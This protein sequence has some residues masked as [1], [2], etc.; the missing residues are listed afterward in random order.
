[1][2]RIRS[3]HPGL[4]TDEAFVGLSPFARLLNM[5]IWNECDDK[6]TFPWSP[7]QMKMR[8]LPADNVD[9]AVLMA[10]LEAADFISKYQVGGKWFGAVRNFCKFQRPKKPNDINPITEEMRNY[11]GMI[12]GQSGADDGAVPNQ[13]PTSGE[14]FSQ[15]EDGEEDEGEESPP[16]PLGGDESKPLKTMIPADWPLPSVEDLPPRARDC[17]RQWTPTS[18]ETHGEAFVSY[19]RGERKLKSDWRLTWANR[20]IALHSQVMRDQKFG[21]APTALAPMSEAARILAEKRHAA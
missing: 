6:G 1:M 15:M 20:V 17:A 19:W 18:Y 10:E 21:N 9:A 3:I 11:V 8:I 14:K 4:W 16:T 2:S 5:G 7:L 13:S 12:G